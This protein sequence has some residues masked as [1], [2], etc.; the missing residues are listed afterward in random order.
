SRREPKNWTPAVTCFLS[1]QCSTRWRPVCCRFVAAFS[2]DLQSDSGC[3]ASSGP[4]AQSRHARGFGTHHRQISG[5]R[6]QP[7]LSERG[8][9]AHRSDTAEA[10]RRR[11]AFVE[12]FI[13]GPFVAKWGWCG[14]IGFI[15][16][17]CFFRPGGGSVRPFPQAGGCLVRGGL[18]GRGCCRRGVFCARKIHNS[19]GQL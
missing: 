6:S 8:R 12:R 16:F 18:A 13:V 7:A 10:R 5:E 15:I 17:F 19:K 11:G 3:C 1:A 9:S 2:G 14:R 4:A